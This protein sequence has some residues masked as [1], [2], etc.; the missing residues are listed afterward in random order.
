LSQTITE[1]TAALL[2]GRYQILDCIGTGGMAS[3]Y[4]AADV[5]LGRSVAIKMLRPELEGAAVRS[6]RSETAVLASLSHPNLVTLFDAHLAPHSPEYLVMELVDGPTLGTHL[7]RG[8]LTTT[9]AAH[10]ATELADA[11]HGVHEA[12]I[13]HRDVKPSNVLLAPTST[14]GRTFRAKLADFGVAFLLGQ[15]RVTMPGMV[16]GTLGYLAPEQLRGEAPTPA[17]DIY[18]LGL[19]LLEALTAQRVFPWHGSAE[20]PTTR[21]TGP[22]EIP[23]DLPDEWADLLRRMTADDPAA[24]PG[25]LDVAREAQ[26][27]AGLPAV[28]VEPTRPLPAPTTAVLPVTAPAAEDARAARSDRRRRAAALIAGAAA[29]GAIVAGLWSGAAADS[30][31]AA[32]LA[33]ADAPPVTR[34]QPAELAPDGT[35]PEDAAT[36]PVEGNGQSPADDAQKA[37]EGRLKEAQKDAQK[38]AEERLKEEQ[39]VAEEARKAAEKQAEEAQ[40]QGEG[41]GKKGG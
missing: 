9:E 36:Q 11:L 26:R 27:L 15:A 16:V 6:A 2:D 34:Q 10:L 7:R 23:D 4:R 31:A 17:S 41:K 1:D 30:P 13:V 20:A 35:A 18:A 33:P 5:L 29:V 25:A 38:A 3:V 40:K 8:P 22:I 19:V 24:R 32:R 28:I 12:G 14:P 21:R 39:K 37:A